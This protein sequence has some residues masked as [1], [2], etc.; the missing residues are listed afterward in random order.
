MTNEDQED[1]KDLELIK[2]RENQPT[3]PDS[4]VNKYTPILCVFCEQPS[5]IIFEG[6]RVAKTMVRINDERREKAIYA[7]ETPCYAEYRKFQYEQFR[8]AIKSQN[9]VLPG[10]AGPGATDGV[11]GQ[12]GVLPGPGVSA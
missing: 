6:M 4:E 8:A 3:K 5:A 2:S 9:P 10:V 1:Q 12:E 11:G 7:H